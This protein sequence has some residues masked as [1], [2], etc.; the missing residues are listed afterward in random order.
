MNQFNGIEQNVYENGAVHLYGVDE[1]GKKTHISEQ[2][3]LAEYGYT[4]EN[5]AD[6][7]D[8]LGPVT[9][10][11]STSTPI[12]EVATTPKVETNAKS[13]T[14]ESAEID[15]WTRL[16]NAEDAFKAKRHTLTHTELVKARKAVAKAEAQTKLDANK[17]ESRM[18]THMEGKPVLDKRENDPFSNLSDE[19]IA[20][21][22]QR[23]LQADLAAK[24]GL[25][26]ITED[27]ERYYQLMQAAEAEVNEVAPA[28]G[29]DIHEVSEP[30]GADKSKAQEVY[31][32]AKD[33]DFDEAQDEGR[34]LTEQEKAHLR[35]RDAIDAFRL[36]K[37]EGNREQSAFALHVIKQTF[38][39]MASRGDW[40][41]EQINERREVLKEIL[42]KN[43]QEKVVAA[44]EVVPEEKPSKKT[45][46]E[47]LRNRWNAINANTGMIAA[48][49]K[50]EKAEKESKKRRWLLIGAAALLGAGALAY[51][52]NK[53]G[54]GV[55]VNPFD[56]DGL[57]LN[58][59]NNDDK[60][61]KVVDAAP[62]PTGTPDAAQDI[63][64]DGNNGPVS[65]PNGELIETL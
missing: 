58:P 63:F 54:W 9:T 49:V 34:P 51:A 6:G 32:W 11:V 56:G 55:D 37:K 39:E 48:G 8:Q 28:D 50:P 41:E 60:V 45:I 20:A 12:E 21:Q 64:R 1:K 47:R 10:E 5:V 14:S 52:N 18:A 57:D 31:D 38:D 29:V 16:R 23:D 36:A 61:K 53:Y 19:E 43:P 62:A 65:T 44:A 33:K 59:F 7:R 46:R 26:P 22:N 25:D 42:R 17:W 4:P 2:N 24:H 35:L 40:T 13:E 27:D 15:P 3:L 30:Q